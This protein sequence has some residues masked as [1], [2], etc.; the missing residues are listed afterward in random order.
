MSWQQQQEGGANRPSRRQSTQYIQLKNL[1]HGNMTAE[2]DGILCMRCILYRKLSRS[3]YKRL[4]HTLYCLDGG[5]GSLHMCWLRRSRRGRK[6]RFRT[7]KKTNQRLIF[8]YAWK[9]GNDS[10]VFGPYNLRSK[11]CFDICII[12]MLTKETEILIV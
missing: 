4:F 12:Y 3:L 10:L 2:N 9:K 6:M 5:L 1:V 8:L 11:R 7:K